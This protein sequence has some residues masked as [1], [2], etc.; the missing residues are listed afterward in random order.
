MLTAYVKMKVPMLCAGGENIADD[1]SGGNAL[2][3]PW[4]RFTDAVRK[5]S[6][7]V[8]LLGGAWYLSISHALHSSVECSAHLLFILDAFAVL[9]CVI[10]R[11]FERQHDGKNM[12]KQY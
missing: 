4:E 8:L 2:S 10:L 1:V 6:Y 3:T 7:E 9:F 12:T 11:T 5:D